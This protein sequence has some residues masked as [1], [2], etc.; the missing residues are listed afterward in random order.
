[1]QYQK[2]KQPNQKKKNWAE[3]LLWWSRGYESVCSYRAH[4]FD[5][6]SRKIPHA[7]GQ[8]SPWATATE[9]THH[10]Y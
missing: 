3:G 2:N 8:L 6:W 10:N 5:P 9:P 4:G 1:M 7:I